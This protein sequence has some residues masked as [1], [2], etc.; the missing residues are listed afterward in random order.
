ML[1]TRAQRDP[2]FV[3]ELVE[4]HGAERIVASVDARGGQVAVEGWE[5]ATETPVAAAGRRAARRSG[6][7]R[8][9]YTPVEVDGTLD[10]PGPRRTRRDR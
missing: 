8:F 6:S 5:Q 4:R 10:G 1:G 3:G 2:A 7:R 9:V